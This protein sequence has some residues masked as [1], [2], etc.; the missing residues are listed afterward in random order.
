[1]NT[2]KIDSDKPVVVIPIDEY[3]AMK[4]TIDIL[5]SYP[6]IVEELKKERK[7]IEQGDFIDYEEFKKRHGF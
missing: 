7:K 4:E 3:E 6:D 5:S 1:M 2:I